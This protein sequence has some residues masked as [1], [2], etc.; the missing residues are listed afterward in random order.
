MTKKIA[1]LGTGANGSCI[2]ADL[3]HSGH[4]VT[5]IDQWPAHVETM[6]SQGL[7]IS[8]PDEELHVDVDAL[9]ICDLCTLNR[10]FDVVLICM[11]AYDTRWAAELIKPYLADDAVVVGIQNAMTADD[12]AEIVG[13]SRTIGCVVELASEMFEP[14]K[15]KRSITRAKTWFGIGALDPSMTAK[16]PDI[17]ALL[18]NVGRVSTSENIRSA[19]WMK[20]IV[21]AMSMGPQ[22]MLGLNGSEAIKLPGVRDIML[23]CGEEA[24]RAGQSL[25]YTI[26]PVFG[27]TK[28]DI[29]GSNRLL[30]MLLDKIVKDV[31]TTSI[32]TVRQDHIKGR[33]SEVDLING[34]AV[35][36]SE[37]HG[38]SAPANAMI[39]EITRRIHAGELQL[40]PS[41]M[42]L[43]NEILAG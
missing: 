9:H 33:Y 31:G 20:L 39:V 34:L 3:I 41:N 36:Q 38:F 32:D 13:P 10:R 14:G 15:V 40:D 1:V 42:E 23:K 37:K 7:H 26:E 19:K 5:M 24:L 30:E 2:S 6:R 11:K 21:N 29:E 12:I 18:K 27:L 8:L 22:A 28:E 4:D 17:E 43:A 25:G 35:S 16:V